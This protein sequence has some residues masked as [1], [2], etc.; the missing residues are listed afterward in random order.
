MTPGAIFIFKVGE[1]EGGSP[2]NYIFFFLNKENK[3]FSRSCSRVPLELDHMI[4]ARAREGRAV[5]VWLST[6]RGKEERG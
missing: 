3:S 2:V 1:K 5:S 4:P 6:L